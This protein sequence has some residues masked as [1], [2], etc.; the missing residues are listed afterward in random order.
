MPAEPRIENILYGNQTLAYE[1]RESTGSRLK[2]EVYPDLRVVVNVPEGKSREE[3]QSRVRKRTGWIVRHQKEFSKFHPLPGPKRYR[4][5]ESVYY[6]GRQYILKRVTGTKPSVKL[7]GGRLEV[8]LPDLQD[9]EVTQKLVEAWY[10][11]KA[12]VYLPERVRKNQKLLAFARGKKVPVR[13]R[14]MSSR[15]GSCSPSG[16][17]T[18][19]PE[20][21][22]APSPCIDYV[23]VHELCHLQVHDHGPGF[24]RLLTNVMPDW[25][26][27]RGRLNEFGARG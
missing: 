23:I 12:S 1:V 20:L 9:R 27:R 13:L 5:G 2:I 22:K 18:L 11:E 3:I 25:K 7:R 16:I 8:E 19:N 6:L 15:W 26:W 17:I 14:K 10:R 4:S 21:I 24:Y